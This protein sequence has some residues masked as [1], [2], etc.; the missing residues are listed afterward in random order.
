MSV[1]ACSRKGCENIMCDRYSSTH[2]YICHDC[3]IELKECLLPPSIFM[4]SDKRLQKYNEEL[5]KFHIELMEK[6]FQVS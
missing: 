5:K 6:E 4:E 1:M 3:F 2:G